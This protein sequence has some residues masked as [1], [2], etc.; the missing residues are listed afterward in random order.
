MNKAMQAA[1][2]LA[3]MLAAAFSV[4]VVADNLDAAVIGDIEEPDLPA[5]LAEGYAIDEETGSVVLA[6]DVP[7]VAKIGESQFAS[8]A[9]AVVA[10][11]EMTGNVTITILGK[12]DLTG[13][14]TGNTLSYNLSDSGI[15]SLTIQGSGESASFTSG[16]DGSGIDVD[17]VT[18]RPVCPALRFELPADKPLTVTGITF[19]DDLWLDNDN[20]PLTFTR[21]TFN[22]S[23][24]A[25]PQSDKVTFDNNVFDFKGTASEFYTNNAFP[26]WFKITSN[27][28]SI[29]DLVFINNEVTGYRGVHIENRYNESTVNISVNHN[30]FK[31]KDS[32]Y[33]NKAIALQLVNQMNGE[34]SFTGNTVD[35]YMAVCLFSKVNFTGTIEYAGNTLSDRCK[36][37]GSSE[38]NSENEDAADAFAASLLP[39]RIGDVYYPSLADALDAVQNGQTIVL[40]DDVASDSTFIL[41]RDVSFTI[42]LAG[43]DIVVTDAVA[44]SVQNGSLTIEDSTAEM[45][46]DETDWTVKY[47]GGKIESTTNTIQVHGSVGASLIL[48][49]GMISSTGDCGVY[50]LGNQTPGENNSAYDNSFKMNGGYIHAQEFGAAVA[51]KGATF[52]FNDGYIVT[53]DNAAIAG[54]GTNSSTRNDGGTT[55]VINGGTAVSNITSEGYIS[56]GIYHPQKGVLEINGGTIVSTNGLGVLMRGGGMD[57]TGGEIIA[58]GIGSGKVGDAKNLISGSGIYVDLRAEYYDNVNIDVAASGGS[59][60]SEGEAIVFDTTGSEQSDD[61]IQVTGGSYSSDVSDFLADGFVYDDTTNGVVFDTDNYEAAV[62]DS[63]GNFV[64]AYT[65]LAEAVGAATEGQTVRLQKNVELDRM[66]DI[67]NSEITIDLEGHTITAS[68]SF[69]S[70]YPND[71][72][73]INIAS[74]NGKTVSNVTIQNGSI[75]TTVG[76]KHPI[77]VYDADGIVLKDLVLNCNTS[78]KGIPLVVSGSSVT[79]GGVMEFIPRDNFPYGVNLG[80]GSSSQKTST[81]VTT[82]AG[83]ELRFTGPSVGFFSDVPKG[84]TANLHFG[85]NTTYYYNTD[86]FSIYAT[87]PDTYGDLNTSGSDPIDGTNPDYTITFS[88]TNGVEYTVTV[89]SADGT[90]TYTAESDGSYILKAG[91]YV[92]T[93]T[94]DGYDD[95]PYKFT[96]TESGNHTVTMTQTPVE[97]TSKEVT[98]TVNPDG[99]SITVISGGNVVGSG[100]GS[101]KVT[102]VFGQQ[103]TV[104]LS[105]DG[106]ESASYTF[107]ATSETNSILSYTL[108]AIGPGDPGIIIPPGDDD[109]YVPIPPTVVDSGSSDNDEVVKIVACAAAAVVA[110]IMAAFL[111]IGHRRD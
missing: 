1:L 107:T 106:Y 13:S 39:A 30:E 33:S 73:L 66:L 42:D 86:S 102:M 105:M 110:A 21:C 82:E 10:A 25:Y 40:L 19:E 49:S 15:T 95:L 28:G 74:E 69:W 12:I 71:S 48:E 22:G 14:F 18:N 84:N 51:G 87:I 37:F 6:D 98:V 57:M 34:I 81:S 93:F 96:V 77:N 64:K 36:A 108:S 35:A 104:E 61:Y 41:D 11:K 43:N 55:I 100:T 78:T 52:T 75:V 26:I 3:V 91:D 7:C 58:E 2:V 59:V 79:L 8:L 32:E 111:I 53:V 47:T 5:D 109:D 92:A 88:E 62:Y 76:N 4:T 23:I 27:D 101:V 85:E 20:G 72:H 46:L 54:N 70:S 103:Y 68:A 56:C 9:D 83:T 90:T 60:E 80:I 97:P 45:S 63:D 65:S 38:W 89:T 17:K 16:I 24:S 94:A 50:V 67:K 99:A 29:F 31:L 44:I